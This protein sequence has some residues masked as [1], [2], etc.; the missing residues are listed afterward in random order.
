M[1]GKS[2]LTAVSFAGAL[3]LAG[4]SWALCTLP[5]QIV[6][7]TLADATKVMANFNAL[8]LCALSGDLVGP[9][10][11]TTG[12]SAIFGS[13][14]GKLLADGGAPPGLRVSNNVALKALP[15]TASGTVVYRAGFTSSGDGGG[16]YY[17]P[18][19]GACV[20]AAGAG[21]NGY[22]V[23]ITGDAGHCWKLASELPLEAKIW[24]IA[25]QL[26]FYVRTTGNDYSGLNSCLVLADPCLT[27][28]Q[29]A[30]QLM[31]FGGHNQSPVID[32]GTGTTF[33]GGVLSGRSPLSSSAT[34]ARGQI[35]VRG[36]GSGTT[37]F[38]TGGSTYP[39]IVFAVQAGALVSLED[40]AI[41][42]PA[43]NG[44]GIFVQDTGSY[45][46]FSGTV[47]I[48]GADNTS[49][50]THSESNTTVEVPSNSPIILAGTF[51]DVFSVDNNS[52]LLL[53]GGT[54]TCSGV[55][56]STN[57]LDVLESSTAHIL[58]STTFPGCGSAT[59]NLAQI[60]N[61]SSVRNNGAQIPG[62]GYIIHNSVQ[63][64]YP[65]FRPTLDTC[66]NG[67]INA[68]SSNYSI[69]IALSGNNSS[70]S[71]I[72]GAPAAPAAGYFSQSP[73]CSANFATSGAARP[74]AISY[75]T[76]GKIALTPTTAG[77]AGEA[78]LITC[79]PLL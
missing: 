24:N 35:R 2:F 34:S 53:D 15:A 79:L 9:S 4:H 12:N 60:L 48:T 61:G 19:A 73:V 67:T 16:A 22:E 8:A 54:I 32:V 51:F 75:P 66:T 18:A 29:A 45:V 65:T 3:L 5:F 76:A 56:A 68:S 70:C 36:S 57:F 17:Y 6:P 78:Y 7:N 42:I 13:G 46:T 59:G 20:L 49:I 14:T 10:S 40:L 1:I 62:N 43:T 72:F 31:L 63:P 38:T 64:Y 27:F 33:A 77:L 30:S 74:I 44:Y 25:G 47:K 39:K 26:T 11:S 21:D 58:S 52:N 69:N 37:K 50:G 41:D 55:V 28:Q 71:I 23:A